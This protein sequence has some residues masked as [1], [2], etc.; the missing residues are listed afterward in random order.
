MIR[1]SCLKLWVG[2]ASY[3]YHVIS[4]LHAQNAGGSLGQLTFSH[5]LLCAEL[6]T[7]AGIPYGEGGSVVNLDL[8][9]DPLVIPCG[10]F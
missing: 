4:N 2:F 3:M 7:V 10:G 5:G 6:H 9:M 1:C 8:F